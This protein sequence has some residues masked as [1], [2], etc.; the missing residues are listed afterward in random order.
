MIT[1]DKNDF[2]LLIKFFSTQRTF[3]EY[4]EILQK[5]ASEDPVAFIK[6]IRSLHKEESISTNSGNVIK[7][8]DKIIHGKST[9][10]ELNFIQDVESLWGN[11]QWTKAKKLIVEM[12]PQYNVC[13]DEG[14][15]RIFINEIFSYYYYF[16]GNDGKICAIKSYRKINQCDL[17][18]A[19]EIVDRFW[20]DMKIKEASQK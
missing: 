8:F 16:G 13:T 7:G 12:C 10:P 19:K 14:L 18:K 20:D 1:F 2:S 9:V 17:K 3:E 4:E 6:M 15:Q 11:T 5:F